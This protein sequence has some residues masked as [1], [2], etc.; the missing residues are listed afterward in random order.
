MTMPTVDRL[1][2]LLKYEPE[3]G[4]LFWLSTGE[5]AMTG[6]VGSYLGGYVDC[7]RVRA[8]R[9]AWCLHYGFEP[10]DFIDHINGDKKDNRISNLRL[11]TK[12]Q[13]EINKPKKAGTSSKYKG[14]TWHKARGK[15][16]AHLNVNGKYKYLGYY[17]I[18]IDAKYAYD[19]A[20]EEF[21]GEYRFR[22]MMEK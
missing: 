12:S 19:K 21:H 8:H 6:K 15:W 10:P 16:L 20:A 7:V 22:A 14:V 3:T 18:E 2:E 4:G 13:N 5:V 11:A 9:V 1:R 17:S